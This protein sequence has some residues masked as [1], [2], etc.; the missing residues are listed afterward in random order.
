[1]RKVAVFL[2]ISTIIFANAQS[3]PGGVDSTDVSSNLELWLQADLITGLSDG[4][5][6]SASDVW[7]DASGNSRDASIDGGISLSGVLNY[8]SYNSVDADF[9]NLPSVSFDIS[10]DEGLINAYGYDARTVFIVFSGVDDDTQFGQL[11]GDYN[12]AQ[13]AIDARSG[14]EQG[15][16]FDGANNAEAIYGLN[17][18][19]YTA[20]AAENTNSQPWSGGVTSIITAE[21]TGNETIVNQVLGSLETNRGDFNFDGKIAEIIVYDRQLNDAERIAVENYLASKYNISVANDFFSLEATYGNDIGALGSADGTN[22]NRGA[23]SSN[24][25]R[26][27]DPQSA[28][29]GEYLFFGHDN[30]AAGVWSTTEVPTSVNDIQRIGREWQLEETGDVGTVTFTINTDELAALPSGYSK[31][32]L[33]VDDDGDFS[34]AFVYE[35]TGAA[36]ILDVSLDLDLS[37]TPYLSIGVII[38][39]VQFSASAVSGT[40]NS[41]VNLSVEVNYISSSNIDFEYDTS[42]GTA[43]SPTNYTAVA[44]GVGTITAGTQSTTIPVTLLEVSSDLSFDV[45][46]SNPTPSDALIGSQS[47]TTVLINDDDLANEV[48]FVTASSSGSESVD[49]VPISVSLSAVDNVNDVDIFYTVTGG[50]ATNGTDYTTIGINTVTVPSGATQAVFFLDVIDDAFEEESETIILEILGATNANIGTTNTQFTYTITNDDNVPEVQL[51]TTSANGDESVSPISITVELSASSLSDIT[52]DYVVS[53]TAAV[54]SDHSLSSGSV[55]IGSGSISSVISLP[56]ID[57]SD[58]EVSETVIVELQTSANFNLGANTTFTYTIIDNDPFGSTG[59]G[60]VGDATINELWLRA[61]DITGLANGTEL[62]GSDVW[63]D[64]SGN[65]RDAFIDGGIGLAGTLDYPAYTSSNA[66]F[67]NKPTVTFTEADNDGLI[68]SYSYEGRT[69][70][71]VFNIADDNFGQFWG[72]YDEAIHLTA[73]T[74]PSTNGFSFDANFVTTSQAIYGLNGA[75]FTTTPENND[76]TQTY[77]AATTTWLQPNG[78]I[79]LELPIR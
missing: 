64:A 15:F 6:L 12:I 65:G 78:Q 41:T 68:N 23:N 72:N 57:D 31:Y 62:S 26:I 5:D 25:L 52:V 1:M 48:S 51:S 10:N 30:Q 8:P 33:L 53:G 32:A 63:P 75:D 19:T 29:A 43:S 69:V 42:D 71:A 77:S 3:G 17:G 79:T 11:W 60:G 49:E 70:F 59:P 55:V 4:A 61:N 45:T 14:N 76:D 35:L 18:A 54:G 44:D 56:I 39:E 28:G 20:S 16:S 36:N 58:S 7:P 50:T 2:F 47:T 27:S 38:P 46:L 21:F 24:V 66:A 67:N 9:N 22:I 37:T 74:R 73:D 34:D 40:E 13:V